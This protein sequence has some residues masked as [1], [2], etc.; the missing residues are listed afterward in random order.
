M[1]TL[2]LLFLFKDVWTVWGHLRDSVHKTITRDDVY[3]GSDLQNSVRKPWCHCKV[4]VHSK[5]G[6]TGSFLRAE[7][8]SHL[9]KLQGNKVHLSILKGQGQ[10]RRQL[11]G[12]GTHGVVFCPEYI[13]GIAAGL[14]NVKDKLCWRNLCIHAELVGVWNGKE[15]LVGLQNVPEKV[16]ISASEAGGLY[17]FPAALKLFGPDKNNFISVSAGFT[18]GLNFT[19]S[20]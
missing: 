2:I 11:L 3:R 6:A 10:L 1:G 18:I 12:G 17:C 16:V 4:C 7:K 14:K 15:S 8:G 19:I 5:I 9:R 13:G 20:S